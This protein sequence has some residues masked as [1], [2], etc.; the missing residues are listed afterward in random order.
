MQKVRATKWG[1]KQRQDATQLC[2]TLQKLC[3]S[4]LLTDV[5]NGAQARKQAMIQLQVRITCADLSTL[6]HSSSNLLSD[7]S[8]PG[9]AQ[10]RCSFPLM[11]QWLE[12]HAHCFQPHPLHLR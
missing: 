9:K 1:A 5:E 11:L 12:L 7:L 2:R 4:G 10:I 8:G 6:T 3:D